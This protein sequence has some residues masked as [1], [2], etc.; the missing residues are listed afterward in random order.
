MTGPAEAARRFLLAC[1]LGAGLGLFYGAL[2]PL[3][4]RHTVLSDLLFAPAMIWAW[5]YL[6]FGVCAGDIRLGYNAGLL[7]GA[8][9]WEATVGKALRPVFRAIWKSLAELWG[10][11]TLP[12][13]KIR[14]I[15]VK[16]RKN[17]LQ[18]AKNGLQ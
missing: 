12:A 4:P 7:L 5:I 9:V 14:K 13:K 18:S 17:S 10:L 16:L 2:R 1:L 11:V 15:C 3:R 8:V 6:S